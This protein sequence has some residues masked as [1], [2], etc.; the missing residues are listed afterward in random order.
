MRLLSIPL[1]PTVRP[2]RTIWL[3]AATKCTIG[4]R[5]GGHTGGGAPF[6]APYQRAQGI[7]LCSRN[8]DLPLCGKQTPNAVANYSQC[9]PLLFAHQ[10][11]ALSIQY[12][13]GG[14]R[15]VMPPDYRL[16]AAT[17][18]AVIVL[19][20]LLYVLMMLDIAIRIVTI[21]PHLVNSIQ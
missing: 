18:L 6:S 20:I 21:T 3:S 12:V 9:P 11:F 5:L 14:G 16:Q 8:S 7:R 15:H 2:N 19:T 1:S 4:M 17:L 13:Y 10:I